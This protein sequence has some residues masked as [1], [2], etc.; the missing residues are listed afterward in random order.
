MRVFSPWDKRRRQELEP[1]Y[2]LL[3]AVVQRAKADAAGQGLN[4]MPPASRAKVQRD[5]RCFLAWLKDENEPVI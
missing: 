5:A 1:E 2:L 3:L 4:I